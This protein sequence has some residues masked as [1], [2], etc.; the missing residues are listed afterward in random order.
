[1]K[2]RV[3][4]WNVRLKVK[5]PEAATQPICKKMQLIEAEGPGLPRPAAVLAPCLE[6]QAWPGE[7]GAG[8][9]AREALPAGGK[10][11]LT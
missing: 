4:R 6:R 9:P 8:L 1:M 11:R 2:R 10:T 5:S 3:A 7:G